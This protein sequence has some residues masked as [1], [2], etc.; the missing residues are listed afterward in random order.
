MRK[1]SA[2]YDAYGCNDS[3]AQR[4]PALEICRLLEVATLEGKDYLARKLQILTKST[5]CLRF[6]IFLVM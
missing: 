4:F 1:Q 3:V 6:G 5:G 2:N